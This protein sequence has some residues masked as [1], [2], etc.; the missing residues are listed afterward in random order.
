MA[1]LVRGML[2]PLRFYSKIEPM[3]YR[4][5]LPPHLPGIHN[6]FHVSMLRKYEPDPS[7]IITHESISV[8]DDLSFVEEPLDILD[9]KEQVL[10]SKTIRGSTKPRFWRS[11]PTCL[12]KVWLVMF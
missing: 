4:P 3:A 8:R 5:T 12:A 6:V 9:R 2:D 7:H 1:N 10:R 11:T